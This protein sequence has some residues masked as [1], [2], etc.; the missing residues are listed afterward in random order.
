MSIIDLS[1]NNKL[2]A[3]AERELALSGIASPSSPDGGK[4]ANYA[5]SLIRLISTQNQNQATVKATLDVVLAL[6]MFQLMSP[7]TGS[8]IEWERERDGKQV[9]KRYKAVFRDATGV[10]NTSAIIWVLPGKNIFYGDLPSGASSTV[11]IKLPCYP[12][13]V[14]LEITEDQSAP[15]HPEQY[16]EVLALFAKQMQA[17]DDPP[18]IE[19]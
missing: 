10:Y 4:V 19:N 2:I 15:L 18:G 11:P 1:H 3:H 16:E 8:E 7:L 12:H 17:P 9:N 5:M 6:C 13:S 14:Q